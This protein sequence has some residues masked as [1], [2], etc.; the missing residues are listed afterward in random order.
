MWSHLK[1]K[2]FGIT[3]QCWYGKIWVYWC[4]GQERPSTPLT[5]MMSPLPKLRCRFGFLSFISCIYNRYTIQYNRILWPCLKM[6]CLYSLYWFLS[7]HQVLWKVTEEKQKEC[8][9]KGKHPDVSK[10]LCNR[11]TWSLAHKHMRILWTKKTIWSIWLIYLFRST[12]VTTYGCCIKW[13]M[14]WCTCA[15]QMPL[16]PPVIS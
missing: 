4:W 2:V 1:R 5:S 8:T 3:P 11:H 14:V 6:A 7:T 9:S 10:H 12:V 15:G 13:T 16:A